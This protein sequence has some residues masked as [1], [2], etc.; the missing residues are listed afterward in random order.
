MMFFRTA[1]PVDPQIFRPNKISRAKIS[2]HFF[3][4]AKKSGTKFF[5]GNFCIMC[6]KMAQFYKVFDV[7]APAGKQKV[8]QRKI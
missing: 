7:D 4:S 1:Q 3:Q 5:S 2:G 8:F 6:K